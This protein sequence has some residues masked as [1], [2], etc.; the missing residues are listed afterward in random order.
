MKNKH[1]FKYDNIKPNPTADF[2]KT[3]NEACR[4]I[5]HLQNCLQQLTASNKA[6]LEAQPKEV[7]IY[8][9]I[10]VKLSNADGNAFAIIAKCS[11][12]MQ[13]ADIH[14]AI[15]DLFKSQA[16]SSDYSNLLTTCHK[17]FGVE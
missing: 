12:A 13:T 17:W 15:Q 1:K 6:I 9:D 7:P 11:N 10:K 4:L 14:P 8:P 3:Y 5:S 16:I 2:E